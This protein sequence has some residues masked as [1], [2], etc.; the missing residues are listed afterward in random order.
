MTDAPV[1][2]AVFIPAKEAYNCLESVPN[3]RQP[4]LDLVASL[5]RWLAFQSDIEY[6]SDPPEGYLH[7]KLDLYGNLETI[8]TKVENREY[9]S[10][11]DFQIDIIATGIAM[12]D[13]HVNLGL[14]LATQVFSY[15]RAVDLAAVSVDGLDI[16]QVYVATDLIQVNGDGS[17]L[18]TSGFQ[19]SPIVKINDQ[20]VVSFLLALSMTDTAQD[21]DANWNAVFMP[22]YSFAGS[23]SY[24]SYYPGPQTTL[25]F[26]NGT[27]VSLDN[28]AVVSGDL[29]WDQDW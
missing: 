25:T 16:P 29:F 27:S 17:R 4:A 6:L 1:A 26:A 3:H 20:D 18:A 11:Y 21:P 8:K 28:Y 12:H 9:K 23:F 10:E 15:S 22:I 5:R 7:E 24:P 13:G 14:D 2:N 19:P